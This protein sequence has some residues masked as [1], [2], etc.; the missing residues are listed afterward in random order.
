MPLNTPSMIWYSQQHLEIIK[1]QDVT[2]IDILEIEI[3]YVLSFIV[4][5]VSDI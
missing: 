2:N 1:V 3:V 4:I 5:C